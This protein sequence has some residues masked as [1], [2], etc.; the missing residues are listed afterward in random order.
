MIASDRKGR[1]ADKKS[2]DRA[3]D[4]AK[5]TNLEATM[6][7]FAANAKAIKE[8]KNLDDV[9]GVS[10]AVFSRMPSSKAFGLRANIDKLTAE[11]VISKIEQLK[12]QSKTGATGFGQLSNQ[13]GEYLKNSIAN[14]NTLQNKEDFQAQ[15]DTIINYANNAVERNRKL[16]NAK[17]SGGGGE[18]PN[19]EATSASLH[20]MLLNRDQT[21][22]RR[23][24]RASRRKPARISNAR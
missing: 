19:N 14:L 2:A 7:D 24:E 4:E 10:G 17:Y 21:Q 23:S 12:S 13:E 20:S 8:H 16:Y 1:E 3:A 9:L 5:L 15:L 6:G 18:T 22:R 11:A